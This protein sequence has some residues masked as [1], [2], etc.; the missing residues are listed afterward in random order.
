MPSGSSPASLRDRTFTRIFKALLDYL[1]GTRTIMLVDLS[2]RA[3]LWPAL[4]RQC[5]R[6]H[7]RCVMRRAA[8]A[9]LPTF[10]VPIL[11]VAQHHAAEGGSGSSGGSSGLWGSWGCNVS[12]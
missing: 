9:V 5:L 6:C 7:R 1:N 3:A 4:N 8:L 12:A 11:L 2:S 10:F